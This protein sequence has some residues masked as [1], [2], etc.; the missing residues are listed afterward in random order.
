MTK[1]TILFYVHNF[2]WFGHNQ[3]LSRIISEL[4]HNFPEYSAILLNSGEKQDFLFEGIARLKI[5]NLPRFDME[6]YRIVANHENAKR[7]VFRK[8]VITKVL[9]IA[10]LE[11]IVIEHFPFGRNFLEEELYFLIGSYRSLH[12][13]GNVFASVR[14]IVDTSALNDRNIAFFDRILVHSDERIISYRD[15]IDRATHQKFIYTGYITRPSITKTKDPRFDPVVLMNLWWGQ[16]GFGFVEDFLR[17]AREVPELE[18]Y[19]MIVSLGKQYNEDRIVLLKALYPF[20]LECFPYIP[21]LSALRKQA[22]LSVSMGGYNNLVEG[23]SHRNS[24]IVYPRETDQEQTERL[25]KF[26]TFGDWIYDGRKIT[27]SDIADILSKKNTG[28][29][30]TVVENVR[31]DGAFHTASFLVNFRR[32]QYIKIRLTNACNARCDMCGVIQRPWQHNETE[33]IKESILEFYK[34]G[35]SIVNF[36][37]GE[38]TIHKGFWEL[39][40]FTKELGLTTSVS[41]NGSTLWKEFLD[42]MAPKGTRLIDYMDI[43][44]DGLGNRQ[45]TRRK[46]VGLFDAIERNIPHLVDQGIPLHIN[47]TVRNDNI[48]EMLDISQ[49]FKGLGVS[50]LSF[51]MITSAPHN[52]TSHYIPDFRSLEKFYKIDRTCI[53]KEAGDMKISFSPDYTGEDFDMFADS[54]LKNNTFERLPGTMCRF[55][56]SKREIR[57]NEWWG[58]SPCCEIDNMSEW[59]GNINSSPLLQIICSRDYEGFL[60]RRFPYIS[61]FCLNC[62]I[63]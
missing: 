28:I 5:I 35:G 57:I 1:K 23:L 40:Q 18:N 29:E 37:G 39:L 8:S 30:T 13:A 22:V 2:W 15:K 3:R 52:D 41:T 55:I 12:P 34:I 33:K 56:Q 36:T 58:I 51:G 11:S 25:E 48:G 21:D 17:K 16:D 47:V 42:K 7:Q 54:I 46:Y 6:D 44:V 20:P 60:Q 50:S 62:K 49:Y 45:D 53:L 59:L 4:T 31:F 10:N 61:N 38:P 14:D 9:S 43:S 27:T 24:V 63:I 26:Q 32:Y 19:T